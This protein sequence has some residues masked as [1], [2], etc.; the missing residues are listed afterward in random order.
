MVETV[1]VTGATGFIAM[2]ICHQL[3]MEGNYKV[4][5]TVRS[6]S[7]TQRVQPLQ[8]LATKYSLEL[9]EADLTSPKGWDNAVD[10]VDYVVHTASPFY[11]VSGNKD[12]DEKLVHPAVQGV[13]NVLNACASESS[14]VSLP[15]CP[16]PSLPPSFPLSFSPSLS[17]ACRATA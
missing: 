11:F 10:E 1:L 3:L 12:A 15:L 8:K 13:L 14:K 4:R 9:V 6:L 17:A 2:E 5:G 16:P 7:N